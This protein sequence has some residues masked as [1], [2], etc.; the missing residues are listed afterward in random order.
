MNTERIERLQA[1]VAE[2]RILRGE[3]TGKDVQGR[4]TACLMA[5]LSPEAGEARSA[6]ACPANVMPEWLARLTPEL[7][8]CTSLDYWPEFVRDYAATA[9]RWH[10]LDDVAWRRVLA[11]VTLASLEIVQPH[12]RA[13]VVA[14]VADLWRRVLDGG[15]PSGS[16]WVEAGCA[17]VSASEVAEGL[18]STAALVAWA[19]V[20]WVAKDASKVADV[21]NTAARVA[22]ASVWVAELT[23]APE[24]TR[25][26]EDAGTA[27][28]KAAWDAI[29]RATLAAI[30]AECDAQKVER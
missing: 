12:D 23:R 30:N 7:D 5:A 18:E 6:S 17:A 29:A 16:E 28:D 26:A 14:R 24:L 19:A 22:E 27:A 8:D 4:E 13:G 9:S 25:A 21:A 10:A 2:G 20:A 3:W 15:K 11:R 1:Y